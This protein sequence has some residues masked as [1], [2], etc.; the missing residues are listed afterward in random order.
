MEKLNNSPK[1]TVAEVTD[2]YPQN[3]HSP[4]VK[5]SMLTLHLAPFFQ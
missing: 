5:I 4:N 1:V 3:F 2:L